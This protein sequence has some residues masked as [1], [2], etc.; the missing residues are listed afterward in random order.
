MYRS[1][2]HFDWRLRPSATYE[3]SLLHVALCAAPTGQPADAR[4]LDVGELVEISSSGAVRVHG[5]IAKLAL[6]PGD[7]GCAA[8][9]WQG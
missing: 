8:H 5:P 1:D 2:N 7:R 4:L 3:G 9:G 6:E